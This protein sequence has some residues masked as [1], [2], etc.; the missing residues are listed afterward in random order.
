MDYILNHKRLFISLGIL[1]IVLFS[2]CI[3]SLRSLGETALYTWQVLGLFS[4][5]IVFSLG[6]FPLC[7]VAWFKNEREVFS[8]YAKQILFWTFSLVFIGIILSIGSIYIENT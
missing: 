2:I 6:F 1:G 3:Y 5:V 8:F 7:Y 4:S